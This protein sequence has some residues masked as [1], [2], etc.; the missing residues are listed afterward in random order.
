M[1]FLYPEVAICLY[2][3]TIQSDME[4]CCHV[5]N[6]APSCYMDMLADT[7]LAL[8]G[9]QQSDVAPNKKIENFFERFFQQEM[10]K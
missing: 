3:S 7:N 8:F 9:I 2:K 5:W 10:L 6:G 4:Y 1:N